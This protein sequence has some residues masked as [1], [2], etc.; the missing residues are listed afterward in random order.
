MT[1]SW[2]YFLGLQPPS[3]ESWLLEMLFVHAEKPRSLVLGLEPHKCSLDIPSKK[4]KYMCTLELCHV[5]HLKM[6]TENSLQ[7]WSA[8]VSTVNCC[9]WLWDS[10]DPPQ[11]LI[12]ANC[13]RIN[14]LTNLV[15]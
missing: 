15:T 7:S 14:M 4:V 6:I 1:V 9:L 13:N 11:H 3:L 10:W 8:D 12:N 2:K 5:G